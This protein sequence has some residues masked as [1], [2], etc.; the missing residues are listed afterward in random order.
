MWAIWPWFTTPYH[1]TCET[2]SRRLLAAPHVVDECPDR[3]WHLLQRRVSLDPIGLGPTLGS[4]FR[5]FVQHPKHPV[6]RFPHGSRLGDPIWPFILV[7]LMVTA[8]AVHSAAPSPAKDLDLNWA[9]SGGDK[10]RPNQSVPKAQCF[11]ML[12]TSFSSKTAI[13]PSRA[14]KLWGP[15][16]WTSDLKGHTHLTPGGGGS[17]ASRDFTS[18]D[19]SV[20]MVIHQS[21]KHHAILWESSW[22]SIKKSMKPVISELWDPSLPSKG[23]L[24]TP[25]RR[26]TRTRNDAKRRDDW[27]RLETWLRRRPSSKRSPRTAWLFVF[28][29]DIHRLSIYRFLI[30]LK[31]LLIFHL[32]LTFRFS[33]VQRH[34]QKAP[35]G[36]GRQCGGARGPVATCDPKIDIK[37]DV[38]LGSKYWM[39]CMSWYS[40]FKY[41]QMNRIVW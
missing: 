38:N 37:N 6:G 7:S 19:W 15:K 23:I 12:L 35:R 24:Q 8:A 1:T 26:E 33:V 17:P 5:A 39:H 34:V 18:A 3:L 31:R 13:L 30:V 21:Q 2:Q 29:A 14:W 20:I 9:G 10:S 16:L 4:L 11:D 25:R 40:W 22:W 28:L 41:I 32:S 36:Q 27:R